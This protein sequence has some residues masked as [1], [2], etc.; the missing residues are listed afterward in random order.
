MDRLAALSDAGVSIWLDDLSRER[1]VS[2]SLAE[3]VA[4]DHVVGVTTNPTIFAKAITVGDA[5]DA[6]IGDLAARG[7]EVGEALRALTAFDVRWACDV[8]RP[9]YEASAGVDGR[10]SIEVDPRLAH[11][12]AATIA[13][14]RALWWL[15]DR[16]NLFI[17]IL[18]ARAG[19]E[20][21]TAGLAEGISVNVTLIFSLSRH[22]EVMDAFLAGM[23]GAR[24]AG[25]DLSAIGSVVPGWPGADPP[26]T[27]RRPERAFPHRMPQDVLRSAAR[28]AVI[29][30]GG[31]RAYLTRVFLVKK[32]AHGEETVMSHP[33]S[34]ALDDNGALRAIVE[35]HAALSQQLEQRTQEVIATVRDS[36][37]T[38][39]AKKALLT[40][41]DR[42]LMPHA[43]AE[44]Q[45]LYPAGQK[46]A[47]A[48]LLV[49]AMIGE[50]R[51]LAQHLGALRSEDEPL[52]VATTA[53]TIA[54]LFGSHV[55]KENDLLLPLLVETGADL[56][57]LLHDTHHLLAGH[58]HASTSTNMTG[59]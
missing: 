41:L 59:R 48:A 54:A 11:D 25:R 31:S 17:K 28:R 52:A 23:E 57:A 51:L 45:T 50:H 42:E 8:L 32:K 46:N 40:F 26:A 58:E 9:A 27:W 38:Q 10:V 35:H 24:D 20:A 56:P 1:L 3:L 4:H 43:A 33:T 29:S 55:G 5:Y 2:G 53:A 21:I 49:D 47:R 6:Q 18:A 39:H 34:H 16:P 12:T 7:V 19:L 37:D 13:E 14:M 30:G 15:V 22:D 44:E 36:G